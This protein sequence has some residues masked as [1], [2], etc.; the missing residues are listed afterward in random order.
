MN[1]LFKPIIIGVGALGLGLITSCSTP[2]QATTSSELENRI[3][4]QE[5]QSFTPSQAG[6]YQIVVDNQNESVRDLRVINTDSL[7]TEGIDDFFNNT[8]L[9]KESAVG[10]TSIIGVEHRPDGTIA[11]YRE[12][13]A[14]DKTSGDLRA[15]VNDDAAYCDT[16]IMGLV[17]KETLYKEVIDS[18]RNAGPATA[19]QKAKE[20]VAK[21]GFGIGPLA[22]YFTNGMYGLGL[23]ASFGNVGIEGEYFL[24]APTLQTSL[25][26]TK[27]P[28]GE[29]TVS[30]SGKISSQE[31]VTRTGTQESMPVFSV[32]GTYSLPLNAR[33]NLFLTAGLGPFF[34]QQNTHT[35]DSY[36]VRFHSTESGDFLGRQPSDKSDEK[37][38]SVNTSY[39]GL[40]AGLGLGYQLNNGNRINLRVGAHDVTNKGLDV[41]KLTFSY[42]F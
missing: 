11:L 5:G 9:E 41:G 3:E 1:K 8:T 40:D 14:V 39:G 26:E 42:E 35:T 6:T 28:I 33:K 24:N 25:D 32:A 2:K 38:T 20:A 30:P 16:T 29:V 22:S 19:E 34:T 13:M 27:S 10:G 18:L 12:R 31:F 21:K 37:N 7:N 23:K 4:L 17:T 15:Y 36:E